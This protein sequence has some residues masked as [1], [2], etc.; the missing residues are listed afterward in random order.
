MW[1]QKN[2]YAQFLKIAPA[3]RL[4]EE[5]NNEKAM[6]SRETEGKVRRNDG[7]LN[8]DKGKRYDL[9]SLS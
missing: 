7:E 3:N 6:R 8:T 4:W 1:N 2:T 9:K 5:W